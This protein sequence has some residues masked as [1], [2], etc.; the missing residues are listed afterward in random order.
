MGNKPLVKFAFPTI[1][2]FVLLGALGRSYIYFLPFVAALLHEM[3]HLLVMFVCR[4]PLKQITVLPFGVDIKKAPYIS[5]YKAD[6]A[7]SSAGIIVN[8]IMIVL[9]K[10]FPESLAVEY[11]KQSNIV[12]FGINV[13]PIKTL[14]GGQILEKLLLL[15]LP[16][17]TVEKVMSICSFI[18][19]FLV[20]SLAVWVLFYSGYNFTLLFM[21]MY[22]FVGLFLKRR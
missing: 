2:F 5:S 16:P 7:V 17:D 15:F 12:L 8:I 4:Q 19:I 6:I 21:C 18:C 3:G 10:T 1:V 14:D 20:G 11:F 22:L 9:C 13:L